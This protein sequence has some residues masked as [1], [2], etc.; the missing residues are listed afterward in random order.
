LCS[1]V[2]GRKKQVNFSLNIYATKEMA[3]KKKTHPQTA[4]GRFPW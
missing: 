1:D 4:N 3:T 2:G